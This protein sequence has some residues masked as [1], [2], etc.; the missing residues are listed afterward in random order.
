MKRIMRDKKC[1]DNTHQMT[2][3][4]IIDVSVDLRQRRRPIK[5]E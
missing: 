2:P 1:T 5:Q 3:Y 4:F